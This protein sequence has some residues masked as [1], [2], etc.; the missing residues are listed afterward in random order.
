MQRPLF[1]ENP[2]CIVKIVSKTS[3][4]VLTLIL[5]LMGPLV[6]LGLVYLQSI[7]DDLKSFNQKK[8][9][10]ILRAKEILLEQHF[11]KTRDIA[12]ELKDKE[13]FK[14]YVKETGESSK[15]T[16]ASQK[17]IHDLIF[18][19]QKNNKDWCHYV[20]LSNREGVVVISPHDK[21][22]SKHTQHL[23]F[24]LYDLKIFKEA[25]KQPV[26]SGYATWAESDQYY[27]LLLHPLKNQ[28]GFA[29][30][31]LVFELKIDYLNKL[32][33]E[34]GVGIRLADSSKR[35]ASK[36]KGARLPSVDEKGF[37]EAFRRGHYFGEYAEGDTPGLAYYHKMKNYPLMLCAQ[38]TD[39]VAYKD[40]KPYK[41]SFL[42]AL[43]MVF[44]M[45]LVMVPVVRGSK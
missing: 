32:L 36:M 35:I 43:W 27:Q 11:Q 28:E 4:T 19:I 13:F 30:A 24:Y 7:K 12:V 33:V 37:D 25:L 38:M 16:K 5:L 6:L 44:V 23:N 26:V 40:L 34:E 20:F 21:D 1:R 41:V 14:R 15:L 22:K 3:K 45:I 9:H 2:T 10:E 18:E 29:E 17:E 31:V 8:I 42:V 39:S